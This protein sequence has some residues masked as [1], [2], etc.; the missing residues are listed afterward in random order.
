MDSTFEALGTSR[1][2]MTS[3]SPAGGVGSESQPMGGSALMRV[4][5]ARR[6]SPS[7][8]FQSDWAIV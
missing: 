1:V 6:S 2:L 8:V 3:D 5:S 7:S 4:Q